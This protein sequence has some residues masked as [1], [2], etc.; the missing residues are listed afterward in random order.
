MMELNFLLVFATAL[1]PLLI[2][3]A[4]YHP[5][6]FGKTWMKV[7]GVTEE[8]IQG[9]NMLKIFGFTYILGIILS[10]SLYGFTIHQI[11]LFSL[12]VDEPGFEV[13]GSDLTAWL[14]D[15][16]SKYGDT[17]R[18][19]THG[20]LHGGL[21]AL[22]FGWPI[23]AINSLFEHRGWKYTAIH[24]GFWFV[25]VALMGGVICAYA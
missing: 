25:C 23:F 1:I 19:F 5:A 2:G 22:M 16:S 15:F 21:A 7:S 13:P 8:Q 6:L 17:H 4:W 18:T 12:L 3:F 9:G 11:N 14:A 20:A 10:L 24:V